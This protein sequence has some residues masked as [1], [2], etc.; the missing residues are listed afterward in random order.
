MPQPKISV[1]KELKVRQLIEQGWSAEKISK[2]VGV[3]VGTVSKIRNSVPSIE[4][5]STPAGTG[6]T[7]EMSENEWKISIPHT[8]ICTLDQLVA[9]CKI[10]LEIWSIDRFIVNKWEVGAA[11]G[12]EGNRRLVVE[13]LFQVKAFLKKKVEVVK[14]K[15]DI[16]ALRKEALKYSPKFTGFKPKKSS[17]SGVAVEFS[18]YDHHF[19]ALIWGE[20]TGG[21]DWD[22]KIAT[23]TWKDALES[24][25]NRSRGYNPEMAVLVLGNDQQNADNRAGAT[26]NLTPQSMDSRYHKVYTV[27]KEA[28]K[29][30]IDKLLAEYGRV[31]V[32][33]VPGN[34]DPLATWHLG[35]YLTT[36][37]RNCPGVTIDNAVPMRKW[38]EFGVVMVMFEHGHKGKLPDYDKIMASEKPEMWG[39]TKWREA[40]TGDKHHKTTIETKGAIIRGLSSL[41]PSCAWSTEHHHTGSIRAAEAFVWSKTEGLIGQSTYSILKKDEAA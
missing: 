16:E 12:D 9:H 32:I 37:Y 19:G 39:R 25:V 41:R 11:E 40:H 35:D 3:S 15:A 5:F 17:G 26:E 27:S 31:H 36:W 7:Q 24:L 33:M 22:N 29:W 10:D 13:P 18:L 34:H 4:A 23:Q 14:A 6:Q 30:A 2:E 21:A 8:R 38:W 20:E 28:S 1:E